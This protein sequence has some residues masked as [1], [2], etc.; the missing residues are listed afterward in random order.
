VHEQE[1]GG[2]QQQRE[3]PDD[4]EG[5]A[6]ALHGTCNHDLG[7]GRRKKRRQDLA[8]VERELNDAKRA[9]TRSLTAHLGNL[10][11]RASAYT[12]QLQRFQ[13]VGGMGV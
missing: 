13:C 7:H 9:P 8:A 1:Q 10:R 4:G 12:K 2:A 3:R 6:P 5:Y 11:P